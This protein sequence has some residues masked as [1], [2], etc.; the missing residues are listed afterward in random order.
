MSAEKD[1]NTE[2]QISPGATTDRRVLELL[3]CPVSRG[4]L[5]YDKNR[6]ELVSPL[7]RIAFPIRD[8]IPIMVPS[9]A[10]EL[11]ADERPGA[12]PSPKYDK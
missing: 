3:I 5:I 2:Q 10:R 11:E 1:A 9:E 12:G 6:Q 4:R 8:G 7:V